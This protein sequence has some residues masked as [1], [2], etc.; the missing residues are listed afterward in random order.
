MVLF[1]NL[2]FF[3]IL[4]IFSMLINNVLST[5][6]HAAFVNDIRRTQKKDEGLRSLPNFDTNEEYSL[7]M[8]NTALFGLQPCSYRQCKRIA[9]VGAG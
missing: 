7:Q 1:N 2:L 5:Y 6:T 8:N 4:L 9:I 3:E